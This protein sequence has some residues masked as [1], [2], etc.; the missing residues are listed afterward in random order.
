MASRSSAL[1][2]GVLPGWVPIA[3]T[4]R[5][6]SRAAWRTTSR[7]PLVSGSNEPG[8]SAVRGMNWGLTRRFRRRKVARPPLPIRAGPGDPD[9]KMRPRR[10]P[11]AASLQPTRQRGRNEAR[12]Q[13]VTGEPNMLIYRKSI[14]AIAAVA[15]SAAAVLALPGFSPV[16]EAELA[17]RPPCRKADRL[18]FRPAGKACSQQAWP[19]YEPKCLRDRT[20]ARA[21]PDGATGHRGQ[22]EIRPRVSPRMVMAGPAG[23][24]R[25]GRQAKHE[26]HDRYQRPHNNRT[27]SRPCGGRARIPHRRVANAFVRPGCP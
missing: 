2:R 6:A 17:S 15:L 27:V 4:R 3:S 10:E 9:K 8:K 11:F 14:L 7:W 21:C 1:N 26:P 23:H 12:G 16:V 24:L 13:A 25:F 5:S 18:D 20:Q 22:D 19:Y